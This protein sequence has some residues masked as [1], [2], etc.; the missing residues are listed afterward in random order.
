LI[1]VSP[2]GAVVWLPLH[3]ALS[4]MHD[5]TTMRMIGL[6]NIEYGGARGARG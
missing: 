4:A 3:A 5:N 2:N 1:S 6:D